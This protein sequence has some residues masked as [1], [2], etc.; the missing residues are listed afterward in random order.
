MKIQQ[1][2]QN[3][4]HDFA[5]QPVMVIGDLIA[6]VYLEGRISRISREAPVLILEHEGE[7]V[8]PGGAANVIHNGATLNGLIYAVGVVGND[9]KGRELKQVLA[10]K[11]V[12][13]DGIVADPARPTM[14]K[15]RIMAGGLATVRQQVVR[16]DQESKEPLSET[17]EQ[18]LYN[19]VEMMLPHMSGIIL[20]DYGSGTLT[21]KLRDYVIQQCQELSIP[22]MVDSRYDVKAFHGVTY[23]KQNEA[24]AAAALN[25][26][27]LTQES[28]PEAGFKLLNQMEAQGLL[29][30]QGADGMTLFEKSGQATHIPVDNVSEVYDV[31]G[32]GDT[33]VITMMLALAG[34]AAPVEAARLANVA[35]GLVVR[36]AG[37]ATTNRQELW[38]ALTKNNGK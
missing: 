3:L 20:S 14:T 8:V 19:Y 22:C 32:A 9:A 29:L 21:P 34:G 24:E 5:D 7:K 1:D 16:I 4:I 11:G 28:L 30:T 38:E 17:V 6:D 26:L 15:T 25:R 2:L 33:V 37:T 12:I 13:T 10:G 31:S 27:E 35:A 18:E 36:K 23:V